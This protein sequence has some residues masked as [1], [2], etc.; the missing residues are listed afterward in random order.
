MMV[1]NSLN[2]DIVPA[3]EAGA[4]G[5]HVP[6]EHNWALDAHDEPDEGPRFHRIANLSGLP[7]LVEK[8][9]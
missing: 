4:Y 6:S 1:G 8:I 9:G 2:S 3:L 7:P 5:V